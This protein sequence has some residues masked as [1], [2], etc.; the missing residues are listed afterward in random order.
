MSQLDTSLQVAL[1]SLA[2]GLFVAAGCSSSSDGAC[3]ADESAECTC[4]DGATGTRTCG[5]DGTWSNCVCG[6][7]G[8]MDDGSDADA[9]TADDEARDG[10][11]E[12]DDTG[13]GADTPDDDAA[14]GDGGD[15]GDGGEEPADPLKSVRADSEYERDLALPSCDESQSDVKIIDEVGDWADINDESLRVFCVKPGDYRGAEP[16]DDANRIELTAAGTEQQRRF[17]VY[18]GPSDAHPVNQTDEER[19]IVDGFHFTSGASHWAIVGLKVDTSGNGGARTFPISVRGGADY[20]TLHRILADGPGDNFVNS[21]ISR[22]YGNHTYIQ[23]SVFRNTLQADDQE[24]RDRYCINIAGSETLGTH[25]VSNELYDCTDS[26]QAVDRDEGNDYSGTVIAHNDMFFSPRYYSDGEGNR[27]PEASGDWTCGENAVDIKSASHDPDN[28]FVVVG[29]RMWGYSDS[30]ADCGG[31]GTG[32]T[33]NAI[34]IHNSGNEEG[35]TTR[36][37]EVRNNIIF[38]SE[39][40]VGIGWSEGVTLENNLIERFGH[41]GADSG[42]ESGQGRAFLTHDSSAT[43][44]RGNTFVDGVEWARISSPVRVENNVFVDAGSVDFAEFRIDPDVAGNA[45]YGNS[46]A[47]GD[48]PAIQRDTTAESKN[49]G[50]CVTL[51]AYTDPTERC[52]EYAVST[53]DSPHGAD[54]GFRPPER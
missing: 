22:I 17:I 47:W 34:T 18:D 53:P 6:A 33:A 4:A 19:A 26:V 35:A 10:S 51:R 30:D 7:D 38:E 1:V 2:V 21:Y 39:G 15:G 52:F 14:D 28:P 24:G 16:Q 49:E 13:G 27:D 50:F 31:S 36:Y 46:E 9:D 12:T 29:N 32:K 11:D 20:N 48:E 25:I 8:G 42:F 45:Y 3:S 41:K 40:G 44:V 23:N 43:T 54:V 37:V 5:S